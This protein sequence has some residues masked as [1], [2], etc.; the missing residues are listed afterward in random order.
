MSSPPRAHEEEEAMSTE[1]CPLVGMIV[2]FLRHVSGSGLPPPLTLEQILANT[3]HLVLP[4]EVK[5][6]LRKE[7]L[8]H[9]PRVMAFP[10]QTFVYVKTL[11]ELE[12]AR[13]GAFGDG[14]GKSES[15]DTGT[16]HNGADP[17]DTR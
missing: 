17:P 12:K 1:D 6:W 5:N 11:E 2:R 10:N 15:V 9:N 8:P 13:T 4:E 7:A 16:R 3:G 14:G